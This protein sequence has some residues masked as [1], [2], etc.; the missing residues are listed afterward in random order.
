[1][2]SVN[3]LECFNGQSVQSMYDMFLVKLTAA[4][5]R[6]VPKINVNLRSAKKAPWI[7]GYLKD[8][9][10]KKNKLRFS[11]CAFK[12]KKTIKVKEYRL[13]CKLVKKEVFKARKSFESEIIKEA[14]SNPKVLFKYVNN[15]KTTKQRVKAIR[16]GANQITNDL[17]EIVEILNNKFKSAFVIENNDELPEFEPRING[18]SIDIDDEVI[19]FNDIVERL[20]GLEVDKSSGPDLI[21]GIILKECSHSL[22]LPISLIFKASINTGTLPIQWGSANIV[23]CTKKVISLTLETTDR[24]H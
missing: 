24:S 11:N 9:I 13:M 10:R 4:C 21:Q 16:N 6:Y 2:D 8:L 20:N 7:N 5:N 19:Q 22:A 3:W 15:Q 18:K 17:N 12:W 23:H 14:K 1:M